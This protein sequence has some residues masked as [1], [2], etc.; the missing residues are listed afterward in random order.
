MR[1]SISPYSSAAV[2]A[3]FSI[4]LSSAIAGEN[5]QWERILVEPVFRSEGV[6]A[7]DVNH[8]GKT[9]VLHGD[10]WYEAPSWKMHPLR[11]L[12][13]RGNG[14]GGYSNSFAD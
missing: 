12:K 8:D 11:E 13:D 6:A 1:P 5:I 3:G 9:D 2:A 7:A 4:V 14:A 10:A